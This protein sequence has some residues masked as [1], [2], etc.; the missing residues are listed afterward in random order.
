MSS[1]GSLER[2]HRRFT[3]VDVE[4]VGSNAPGFRLPLS[5][6]E[7]VAHARSA[8]RRT[9]RFV[10]VDAEARFLTALSEVAANAI[11]EHQ[12]HSIDRPII[13]D[14]TLDHPPCVTVIDHGH[15]IDPH[16]LPS[17]PAADPAPTDSGRGL[18][19]ARSLLPSMHLSSGPT[20]TVAFLPL[21]G[22]G[23]VR[24]TS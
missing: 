13:V 18:A 11:A 2:C 23:R 1:N 12:R 22:L 9:I 8:I 4:G 24:E 16:L 7:A 19:I 5:S 20:G 3:G 17:A 14:V 6:Y 10:D 21:D 15:G